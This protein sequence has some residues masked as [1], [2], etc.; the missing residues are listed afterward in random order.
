M[1]HLLKTFIISI[2][3]SVSG[4]FLLSIRLLWYVGRSFF[5]KVYRH[6]SITTDLSCTCVVC[7]PVITSWSWITWMVSWRSSTRTGWW[8]YS[9]RC[10]SSPLWAS[11]SLPRSSRPQTPPT[12][13]TDRPSSSNRCV[14]THTYGEELPKSSSMTT[15]WTT[16]LSIVTFLNN[17]L[18]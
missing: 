1:A 7:R 8:V 16:F 10:G 9:E 18:F 15:T 5:I 17:V 13:S 2:V 6:V 11:P 3:K 12:S 4:I 14:N